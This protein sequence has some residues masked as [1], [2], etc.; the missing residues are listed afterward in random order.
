VNSVGVNATPARGVLSQQP[1]TGTNETDK[2][3]AEML[4]ER[5]DEESMWWAGAG[6]TEEKKGEGDVPPTRENSVGASVTPPPGE[7]KRTWRGNC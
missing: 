3:V 4:Q 5:A 1:R 6:E 7:Y 2:S